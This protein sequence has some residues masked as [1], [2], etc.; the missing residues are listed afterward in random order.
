MHGVYGA[1]MQRES[2][3]V[4]GTVQGVGFR[5]N[6]WRIAQNCGVTGT[7]VNDAEGVLI[8]AW[9]TAEKLN[10][11]AQELAQDAPPLALVEAVERT[12][13]EADGEVPPLFEIAASTDGLTAT[14]IAA[15]AATCPACLEDIRDPSNRRYRYP[16][17][18]CTH[19]GPRLS[20]IRQVPYDRPNTSMAE[21]EL[22][23][24][25]RAEYEDPA[26]RRFHAQPNAC[27]V[28]GPEVWLEDAAGRVASNPDA[29]PIAVAVSLLK[30]GKILAIK[31]IGGFHLACLATSDDAVNT[32]RQ[33]KR[34][35]Q[36]AFALMARDLAV[37][38]QY[39]EPSEADVEALTSRQAPIVILP[40]RSG[41]LATGVA[42]GQHTLGFML[43]YTPLHH[44]LLEDFQVPLVM[45]SGNRSDEPQLIDN[46][47]AREKL[48]D[49]A[50][51]FLM[52]NRAIVNRLD[53]SVVMAGRG[54]TQLLRRARGFAPEP[55]SLHNSFEARGK[56]LALGGEL[57]NTFCRLDGA[58]AVV[59][60]HIGDME[61]A[62]AQR[63][64]LEN[65]ELYLKLYD[66]APEQLAIDAHP[67]YIPS[68]I[69]GERFPELVPVQVQHHHAHVASCMAEHGLPVDA[70][71]VLGVVLDGLGLGEDGTLWGGEFLKTTFSGFERLGRFQPVPMPGG[72]KAMQEPWRNAWA[73]LHTAFGWSEVRRAYEGVPAIDQLAARP[74]DMLQ[75]MSDRGVNSPLGSS[76]GRLFDAVAALLGICPDRMSHEAQAAMELESLA[77]SAFVEGASS[78]YPVDVATTD[79]LS[80]LSWASLWR[81]LLEDLKSATP[82]AL[83]A[84]RFH[85]GLA[86]GVSGVAETLC[87]SHA[88]ATVCLSGGVF[89]NQ[90]M[91]SSVT[92]R[93]ESAGITVLSPK[94]LPANDGG[95]SL[96]QAAVAVAVSA[97]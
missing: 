73:H 72:T 36:K 60:Q 66:F 57:K 32:L 91:L 79:Q 83:I 90:L 55:I 68:R 77:S 5:P 53:D 97:V 67:D 87:R 76:A 23:D 17:T 81:S 44:L 46:D 4:R 43:P 31:G 89:Q 42:P 84:A 27:P 65:L 2:I 39:A 86:V 29:D 96:G 92:A 19:C 11:F 45:T 74:V 71:P 41:D 20:I 8:D 14:N 12:A 7:V 15:D 54:H 51:V 38:G 3:R 95:L 80:N 48:A 50:D 28:C 64:F 59:S 85:H 18:N 82:R 6:V 62:T 34:R 78:P 10:R 30:E 49:I 37:I 13:E 70:P 93:L 63:D 58:T 47:R 1:L 16:F 24:L 21:F 33:R 26:D 40:A 25:C 9:G 52:H 88:L 69:A 35:Y 94:H 61:D 22:C 56:T 75:Q